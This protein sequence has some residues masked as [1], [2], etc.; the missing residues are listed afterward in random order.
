LDLLIVYDESTC[1]PDEAFRAHA[2]FVAD[3]QE[4]VGIPVDL[5]LL[6][7]AEEARGQFVECSG[8]IPVEQVFWKSA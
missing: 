7:I 3:L 5:T 1:R 2:P 8:A 4:T 6:T